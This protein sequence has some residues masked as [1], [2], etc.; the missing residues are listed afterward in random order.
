[1]S[2]RPD[3]KDATT[4]TPGEPIQRGPLGFRK[5]RKDHPIFSGGAI[6]GMKSLRPHST[7]TGQAVT[8]NEKPPG[9]KPAPKKE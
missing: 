5:L 6:V 9:K 8:S 1:M 3:Q 7:T 4:P 2:K